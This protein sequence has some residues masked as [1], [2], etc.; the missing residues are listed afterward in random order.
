MMS[1]RLVEGI[2]WGDVKH[3]FDEVDPIMTNPDVEDVKHCTY[4]TECR[5]ACGRFFGKSR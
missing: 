2:S 4:K 3:A 1:G 5:D